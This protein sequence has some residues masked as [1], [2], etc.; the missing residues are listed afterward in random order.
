MKGTMKAVEIKCPKYRYIQMVEEDEKK[1]ERE[2]QSATSVCMIEDP[3]S[4]PPSGQFLT[5]KRRI[6]Q[7]AK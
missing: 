2:F 6:K 3:E 7:C 4:L 1:I 5:N